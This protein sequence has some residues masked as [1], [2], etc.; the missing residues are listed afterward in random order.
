[1]LILLYSFV[2]MFWQI[3]LA[4][5]LLKLLF[6]PYYTSTDFE[7]H[8]NWLAITHS[9]PIEKWYTEATSEWTLDYPPFFA[10]FE[11]GLGKVAQFADSNMLK[12]DNLRYKS[13][14]TLLFQRLSV[15]LCDIVLAIGVKA[16]SKSLNWNKSGGKSSHKKSRNIWNKEDS[17][18][19]NHHSILAG[20]KIDNYALK[21]LYIS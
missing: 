18:E 7:V 8:R 11:W 21:D 3:V 10:W 14:E 13:T 5:T 1:M 17:P 20:N 16:C 2:I 12:V 6:V 9:L 15:I 4:V 19:A